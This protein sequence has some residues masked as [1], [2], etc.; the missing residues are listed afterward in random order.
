[1]QVANVM[2][3][4]FVYTSGIGSLVRKHLSAARFIGHVKLMKDTSEYNSEKIIKSC[5]LKIACDLYYSNPFL[6][7]GVGCT[8]ENLT[9]LTKFA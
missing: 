6:L 1:M 2:F 4:S 7:I 5:F 3:S 8:R 9:S